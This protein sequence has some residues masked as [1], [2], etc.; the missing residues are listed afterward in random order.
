[1]ILW[2]TKCCQHTNVLL[3]TTNFFVIFNGYAYKIYI[4]LT[5][6]VETFMIHP[7]SIVF[8]DF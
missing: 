2:P 4:I 3:K 1:M 5:L 6:Q 8:F 7:Q